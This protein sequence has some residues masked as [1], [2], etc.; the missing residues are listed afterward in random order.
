MVCAQLRIA[1]LSFYLELAEALI[2]RG[3]DINYKDADGRSIIYC[4]VAFTHSTLEQK[5]P[6]FFNVNALYKSGPEEYLETAVKTVEF[7]IRFGVDLE[8]KDLEGRGPLHVAAWNGTFLLV[9]ILVELGGA[10]INAI[11]NERRSPLHMCSWNGHLDVVRLLVESG[12]N[13]NHVSSTQGA[14]PLL[15]AGM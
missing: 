2:L 8:T 14:S 15:V 13:V 6:P 1:I 9:S 5:G 4:V 3:G 11:D 7:L 12:A 10:D